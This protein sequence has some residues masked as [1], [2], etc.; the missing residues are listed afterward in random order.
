MANFFSV[1]GFSNTILNLEDD[2]DEEEEKVEIPKDL[3]RGVTNPATPKGAH[4]VARATVLKCI[5]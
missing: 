3:E 5:L 4:A 2:D 1:L